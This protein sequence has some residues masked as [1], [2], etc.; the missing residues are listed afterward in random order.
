MARKKPLS[1]L[2]REKIKHAIVLPLCVIAFSI[3]LFASIGIIQWKNDSENTNNTIIDIQSSTDIT[4]VPSDDQSDNPYWSFTHMNMIDVDLSELQKTNPDTIGWIQVPG[5]NINYPF[6]HTTDNHFYLNRSLNKSKNSAGWVFLDYR[7]NPKLNHDNNILYAHGRLDGTMFGS[8]R[9]L[10][11]S[12]WHR[13]SNN[14]FIKISTISANSVWQIFSVYRI[15]V[16]SD[17]IK[18]RFS[19]TAIYTEWLQMIAGRSQISFNAAP[20]ASDRI[21]TLSTCYNSKER[22]VVHAKLIKNQPK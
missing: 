14:H 17:Y 1:P 10:L 16:T 8:L 19:T 12:S 11:S 22:L 9:N 7:N 13:N 21:L 2:Q 15:P 6:V 18:T 4:S 3:S 20:S 5:T